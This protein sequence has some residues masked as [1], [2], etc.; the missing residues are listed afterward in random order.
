V[1]PR[2]HGFVLVGL[3]PVRDAPG[4]DLAPQ[5]E[6]ANPE[7]PPGGVARRFS[8]TLLSRQPLPRG[9]WFHAAIVHHD[10]SL[11]L[12][13]DGRHCATTGVELLPLPRSDD[14]YVS[15]GGDDRGQHAFP[16]RIDEL[17]F[18]YHALA[19]GEMADRSLPPAGAEP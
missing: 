17:R 18:C 12:W 7:G 3:A 15:L 19:P 6:F 11:H 13:V 16:G 14:G 10:G 1:L 4:A 5:V 2:E 8:A 9:V